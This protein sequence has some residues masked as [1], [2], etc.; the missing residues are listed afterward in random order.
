MHVQ[1][2]NYRILKLCHKLCEVDDDFLGSLLVGKQS[3][4]ADLMCLPPFLVVAS[5]PHTVTAGHF[6]G[7]SH[8]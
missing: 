4:L 2:H 1:F 8:F 6:M 3:P 5:N 7:I